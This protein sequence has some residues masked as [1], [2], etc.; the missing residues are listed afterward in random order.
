MTQERARLGAWALVAVPL[1][2]YFA[3]V[4]GSLAYL[5]Y[6]HVTQYA[7]E[8]GAAGA[9]YPGLFNNGIIAAGLAAIFGGSALLVGLPRI[10]GIRSW[11]ALAALTLALWGVA[12]VIGGLFPMPDERHG[13][14]GLALAGQLT[15]LFTFLAIRPVAGAGAFK[16]FL[17]VIFLVSTALLAVMM[18]VGELVTLR[19]VGLWQRGYSASSIVWLAVVGLWLQGRLRVPE[20]ALA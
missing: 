2:Y 13:A 20:P 14:Y 6:S 16:L 4:G 7:S 11:A 15:P 17:I 3:L 8:L 19:N 10:G 12:M 9:P 5:G 1:L 18:G